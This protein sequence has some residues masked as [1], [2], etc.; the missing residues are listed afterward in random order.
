MLSYKEYDNAHAVEIVLGA[1]V[2]TQEFDAVAS[3]LEA[4]IERHGRLRLLE[5]VKDFEGMDATA[6]WHD[7]KFSLRHLNDFSRVAIVCNP[8]T[9]HLWS[10]LV[11]PFMAC[12]V[13]HFAPGEE[14]AARD[15]L[16]WPEGAADI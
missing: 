1:H 8:D 14:D 7:I 3:K 5:I 15:W 2:S 4:F 6:F 13:E 10:S 12:E 11:A 9:H 16:M